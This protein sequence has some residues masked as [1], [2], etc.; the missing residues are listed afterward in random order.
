MIERLAL[1]AGRLLS[2]DANRQ[3]EEAER[4]S[5]AR[6]QAELRELGSKNGGGISTH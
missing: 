2:L 5:Y 4:Y 1:V 3:R 6:R